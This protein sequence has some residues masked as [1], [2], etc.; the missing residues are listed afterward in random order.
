VGIILHLCGM[1]PLSPFF[2]EVMANDSNL[3]F[4]RYSDL[5]YICAFELRCPMDR[6]RVSCSQLG[7]ATY[8]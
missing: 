4:K 1:L 6:T 7:V 2:T 8:E 3:E 5:L